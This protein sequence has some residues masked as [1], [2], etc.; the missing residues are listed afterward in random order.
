MLAKWPCSV[1]STCTGARPP[2]SSMRCSTTSARPGFALV[3]GVG[4]LVARDVAGLAEIRREVVGGD[5]GPLAV[6]GAQRAEQALDAAEILADVAGQQVGRPRL[7]LDRCPAEM[8][9]QP[10]LALPRLARRDVD[11]LARPPSPP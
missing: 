1:A 4:E 8:V 10:R 3:D 9:V 6:G 7:Q 2:A 11:D 5:P